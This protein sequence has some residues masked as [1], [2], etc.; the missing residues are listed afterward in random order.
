MKV[1]L[2]HRALVLAVIAV[3]CAQPGGHATTTSSSAVPSASA[4]TLSAAAPTPSAAAETPPP[5]RPAPRVLLHAGD[6]M[7]GGGGGL[8]QALSLKFEPLGTRYVRDWRVATVQTFDYG[9]YFGKLLD[10]H[11]PDMAPHPSL[12][13]R[14]RAPRSRV[15]NA[16][17]HGVWI[18]RRTVSFIVEGV[19]R[20]A[21]CNERKRREYKDRSLHCGLF[22][23]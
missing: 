20:A 6:S 5:L 19:A 15:A 14:L 13:T 8:A 9:N 3:G 16:R 21:G 2:A 7:V 23:S 17:H 22:S 11:H 18:A 1:G 10:K 4:P 12:G